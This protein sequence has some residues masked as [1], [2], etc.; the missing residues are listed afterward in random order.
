M[1]GGSIHAGAHGG[2]KSGGMHSI[3]E[4][5]HD[6]EEEDDDLFKDEFDP[7]SRSPFKPPNDEEV[8]VTRE[9]EKQKRKL[10]K[11]KA[12]NLKIWEKMTATTRAPL[13]RVKDKHIPPGDTEEVVYNFNAEQRAKISSAMLIAKSRVQF[14]QE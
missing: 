10:A 2:A 12:K 8:F 3:R 13:K 9:T 5:P 4:H 6:N 1:D 14:P 7:N 11:E